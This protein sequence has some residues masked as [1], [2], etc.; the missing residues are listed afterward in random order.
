MIY[1]GTAAVF[2]FL[3]ALHQGCIAWCGCVEWRYCSGITGHQLAS[4]LIPISTASTLLARGLSSM[5]M[6]SS[7][8]TI[9]DTALVNYRNQTKIDLTKHPSALQLQNCRSTNDV[10]QILLQRESEF[11]DYREKHRKLIECFRPIVQVLH[12]FSNV[13]VEA[14]GIVRDQHTTFL[15]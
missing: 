9:L 2:P 14:A 10:L 5:A 4:N 7:F 3:G 8:Q 6:S 13:L 12:T 1:P 11:G 15:I